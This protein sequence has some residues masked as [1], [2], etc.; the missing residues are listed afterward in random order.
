VEQIQSKKKLQGRGAAAAA[1]SV[2]RRRSSSPEQPGGSDKAKEASGPESGL[3]PS[4]L[5]FEP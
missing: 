3:D 4:A 5:R 1:T 2:V